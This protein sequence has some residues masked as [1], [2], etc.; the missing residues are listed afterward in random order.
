[1]YGKPRSLPVDESHPVD[2]VDVNGINKLAAERYHLL[3]HGV[4]GVRSTILRLTNTYGPRQRISCSRQGVA[5]F[6]IGQALRGETIRLYGGGEQ[7]RDFNYVGDVVAAMLLAI[8]T[9]ECL[10]GCFNLGDR[11]TYSLRE[12]TATLRELC[13]FNIQPVDFPATVKVIDI[14]DYQGDFSRFQAAT[15]WEPRIDLPRG[16]AM[17]VDYY[18]QHAHEYGLWPEAD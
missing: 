10:G 17:T 8:T 3:Y 4:H 1:V 15:G 2:P 6:F 7:R 12:F 13:R 5:G 18:R 11:R 14:G 9:D 16:L